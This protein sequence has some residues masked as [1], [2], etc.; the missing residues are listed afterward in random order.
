MKVRVRVGVV[1]E[2][3]AYMEL[4]TRLEDA[5]RELERFEKLEFE[6]SALLCV[7]EEEEA[8]AAA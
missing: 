1:E 2:G 5:V 4:E 7:E 8:S 3:E 6:E